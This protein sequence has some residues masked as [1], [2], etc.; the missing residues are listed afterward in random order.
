MKLLHNAKVRKVLKEVKDSLVHES[1]LDNRV[2]WIDIAKCIG[3]IAIVVGHC[4]TG[5]IYTVVYSFN[6]VI[7]FIL[8][9][10]TFNR[11]SR[12]TFDDR[13]C[14]KDKSYKE[15]FISILKRI[16]IPY[17]FWGIISI[18]IYA[19]MGR[20]ITNVLGLQESNFSVFKNL[21]GMLYANSKSSY[22][23]W[24][25]PLWFLPALVVVEVIWFLILKM[26]YR[27]RNAVSAKIVYSLF[28]AFFGAWIMAKIGY[29]YDMA[30]PFELE[31][32][33]SMAFFFGLG[34]LLRS[35]NFDKWKT[36]KICSKGVLIIFLIL[37]F[38][39]TILLALY[40]GTTDTR[41]DSF[42]NPWIYTINAFL[43]SLSIIIGSYLINRN[44]VMEYIGNR[45]LAI[46]VMH[47]F[48]IMF[49]KM[50]IP[51]I[52]VMILDGNIFVSFG[53]TII[54]ITLC[55]IAE[56]VIGKCVPWCLGGQRLVYTDKKE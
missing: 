26:L 3:I 40:N 1:K 15:F 20:R 9:G 8:S 44:K 52:G 42:G 27:M 2:G 36:K 51:G 12:D 33:L 5:G 11:I 38:I 45:T 22:F 17:L 39:L 25:R 46:L 49:F 48:P 4:S 19:I 53:L 43:A 24:N 54:T 10:M 47:K 31:T 32:A 23:E 28:M 6:S 14:F 30:L 18:I 21:C 55:M 41:T 34:I 37:S 7:F 29:R 35:V 16:I 50:V 13:F 56:W